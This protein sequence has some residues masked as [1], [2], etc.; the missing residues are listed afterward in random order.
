[1]LGGGG[2]F[3]IPTPATA[4]DQMLKVPVLHAVNNRKLVTVEFTATTRLRQSIGYLL[5]KLIIGFKF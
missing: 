2:V 1:V 5:A 3:T 4:A